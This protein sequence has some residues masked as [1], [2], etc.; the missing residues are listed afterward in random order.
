MKGAADSLAR[1]ISIQIFDTRLLFERFLPRSAAFSRVQLVLCSDASEKIARKKQ[2]Y[3]LMI[4]ALIFQKMT[5][6]IPLEGV[7]VERAK[8]VKFLKVESNFIASP[9]LVSL[10]SQS[11][12]S[13]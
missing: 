2:E 8:L 7:A 6:W 1:I 9:N 11:F 3:H 4:R 13:N 10:I 5:N 12:T